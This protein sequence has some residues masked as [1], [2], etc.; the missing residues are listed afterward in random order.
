VDGTTDRAHLEAL[1]VFNAWIVNKTGTLNIR[2]KWVNPNEPW[3]IF[4]GTIWVI[5]LSIFVT[6]GIRARKKPS[7]G[8][9][10]HIVGQGI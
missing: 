6:T 9:R 10:G 8:G 1:G 2:A 7:V 4:T 3:D 5:L